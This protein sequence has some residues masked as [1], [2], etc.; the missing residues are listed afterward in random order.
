MSG[1]VLNMSKQFQ[2]GSGNLPGVTFPEGCRAKIE[3]PLPSPH[4]TTFPASM[5][6]AWCVDTRGLHARGFSRLSSEATGEA[7]KALL[8]LGLGVALALVTQAHGISRALV[9]MTAGHSLH[10]RT[11][12]LLE[13]CAKRGG[14]AVI[15]TPPCVK[16]IASGKL[17]Y[18]TGSSVQ[19]SSV[20]SL[21][22]VRLFATP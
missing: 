1:P 7:L 6:P 5:F 17:L 14:M 8:S 15:Y 2:R 13:L 3:T 19:V 18:N 4:L 11:Q 10:T 12:A 16:W 22:H 9:H 21:S 20:Q